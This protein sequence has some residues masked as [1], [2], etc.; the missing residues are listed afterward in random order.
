M[1]KIPDAIHPCL[2]IR[3]ALALELCLIK[4]WINELKSR[5]TIS[6][7]DVEN[8][9]HPLSGGYKMIKDKL[10]LEGYIG[11]LYLYVFVG[12]IGDVLPILYGTFQIHY[13]DKENRRPVGSEER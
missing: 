11:K 1:E 7:W 4:A 9:R 2:L 6:L 5:D 10:E 3:L 8:I 12:Y 13:G